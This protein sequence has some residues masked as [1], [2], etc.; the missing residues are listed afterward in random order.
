MDMI[1]GMQSGIV[2][3]VFIYTVALG[4]K[5]GDFLLGIKENICHYFI[6][7]SIRLLSSIQTQIEDPGQLTGWGVP[8][9]AEVDREGG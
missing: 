7:Y 4:G 1:G 8:H 3:C 9:G 2:P 5:W 6:L